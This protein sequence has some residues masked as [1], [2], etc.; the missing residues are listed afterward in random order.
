MLTDFQKFAN[1]RGGQFV[2]PENSGYESMLATAKS[3][4]APLVAQGQK[5]GRPMKLDIGIIADPNFNAFACTAHDTD[6]I[7][8]NVGTINCFIHHYRCIFSQDECW[9]EYGLNASEQKHL[10]IESD[11]SK[12]LISQQREQSSHYFIFGSLL[13]LILHEFAHIYHGHAD[14]V[15]SVSGN[16]LQEIFETSSGSV[17]FDQWQTLEWDADQFAVYQLLAHAL[18]PE[19][20]FSVRPSKWTLP[21]KNQFGDTRAAVKLVTGIVLTAHLIMASLDRNP[22][23]NASGRRHPPEYARQY[24]GV[25]T[26][27]FNLDVRAGI[28]RTTGTE[29]ASAGA[30]EAVKAWSKIFRLPLIHPFYEENIEFSNELMDSYRE[31]WKILYPM[32]NKMKRGGEL[33]IP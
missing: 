28:D 13:Y 23:N 7:A 10:F 31:N 1:S 8:I 5:N 20:D 22:I 15:Y 33:S 2:P 11:T 4:V 32:L 12:P 6:L 27:P 19:V 3:I 14:W 21:E 9:S 17:S 29:M 26:I 24:Y 16:P 18:R 25:E 30:L